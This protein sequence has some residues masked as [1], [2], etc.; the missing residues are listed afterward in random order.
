MYYTNSNY[1]TKLHERFSSINVMAIYDS[2][3]EKMMIAWQVMSALS[4]HGR[5][6]NLSKWCFMHDI[7]RATLYNVLYQR[8]YTIDQ[9]IKITRAVPM[10]I[11]LQTKV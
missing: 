5:L 10:D 4:Y 7:N 3:N 9:L 2:G 6:K 11:N 8:N 1:M